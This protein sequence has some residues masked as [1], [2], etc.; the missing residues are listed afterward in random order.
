LKVMVEHSKL[1][2][3][4]L[5]FKNF[6]VMKKHY[7]AYVNS[8]PGAAELRAKLMESNSPE[9]VEVEVDKFLSGVYIKNRDTDTN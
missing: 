3:E 2:V 1:F 5:P 8:F 9:E 7:K 4:L 6:S